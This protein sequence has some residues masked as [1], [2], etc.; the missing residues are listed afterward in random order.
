MGF[1]YKIKIE[2]TEKEKEE[3]KNIIPRG[4]GLNLYEDEIRLEQDGIYI[5][6]YDRPDLW[7]R[8]E[9]LKNYI[10]KTNKEYQMEE[11]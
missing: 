10:E 8:L 6:K 7:L 4:T 11:L 5:V 9:R 1:E 3:I 2:L